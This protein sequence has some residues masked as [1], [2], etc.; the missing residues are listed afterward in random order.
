MSDLSA[1]ILA[2]AAHNPGPVELLQ[3]LNEIDPARIWYI[4]HEIYYSGDNNVR[5][6]HF[7]REEFLEHYRISNPTVELKTKR[8]QTYLKFEGWGK[9]QYYPDRGVIQI[10]SGMGVPADYISAPGLL[11]AFELESS[12]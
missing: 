8:G 5:W 2:V 12:T 3:I 9:V 1:R 10:G 11:R 4:I 7:T 6:G